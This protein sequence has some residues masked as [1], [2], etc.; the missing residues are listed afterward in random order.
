[1]NQICCGGK[2]TANYQNILI[3]HGQIP[4]LPFSLISA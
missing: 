4:L 2:A 3:C 1:M